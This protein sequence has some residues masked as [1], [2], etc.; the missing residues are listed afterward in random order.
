VNE[1]RRDKDEKDQLGQCRALVEFSAYED[2]APGDLSVRAKVLKASC[3]GRL[4]VDDVTGETSA[5]LGGG[6]KKGCK[7]NN[8]SPFRKKGGREGR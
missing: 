3:V 6:Q 2:T 5:A 7:M 4:E 8:E 1:G